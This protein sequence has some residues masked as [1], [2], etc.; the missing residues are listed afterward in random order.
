MRLGIDPP[1][2]A[3][4]GRELTRSRRLSRVA[5]PARHPRNAG[6]DDQLHVA[7]LASS[8]GRDSTTRSAAPRHEALAG[9]A[10][11]CG[12]HG[13]DRRFE[14]RVAQQAGRARVAQLVEQVPRR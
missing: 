12:A 5:A 10:E 9:E 2:N 14:P 11:P 6:R 13:S 7:A 4:D 1:G 8:S 3:P